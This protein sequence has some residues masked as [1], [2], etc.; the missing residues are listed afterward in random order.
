MEKGKRKVAK[1]DMII[2]A[3]GSNLSSKTFGLPENNC[4]QC[5]K[6]LK[7]FFYV[8]KISKFYKSEP[9]PKSDQPWYVNGVV[10]ICT[11]L[12]PPDILKKLFSIENYFKRTRKKRN[13]PRVI[14]LDLISYKNKVLRSQSLILPHPRMHKRKFVIKPICDIDP[15]WKHPVLNIKANILLKSVANQKIFIIKD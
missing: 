2:I 1:K 13:E 10:E 7:N 6:L 15:N 8:K 9:I 14:D 5:L 3:V 12:H 4:F 11:T